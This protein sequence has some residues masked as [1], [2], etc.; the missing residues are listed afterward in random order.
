VIGTTNDI[1][2]LATLAPSD[3]ATGAAVA[4]APELM[5]RIMDTPVRTRRA[6]KGAAIGGV[7]VGVV[8]AAA[9][10]VTLVITA[11][12]TRSEKLGADP[13]PSGAQRQ[14]VEFELGVN[15]APGVDAEGQELLN[16]GASVLRSRADALGI[17]GFEVTPASGRLFAFVPGATETEPAG[18]L[19]GEAVLGVYD[20][21]KIVRSAGNPFL[22]LQ[23]GRGLTAA[24]GATGSWYVVHRR[25][26]QSGTKI[27]V[28]GP[29]FSRAAGEQLA[30]PRG[31]VVD[32]P[33]GVLLITERGI[34]DRTRRSGVRNDYHLVKGL[35]LATGAQ[36]VGAT[37]PGGERRITATPEFAAR[38]ASWAQKV[39]AAARK[40]VRLLLTVNGEVAVTRPASA[41]PFRAGQFIQ[42]G[43]GTQSGSPVYRPDL[44]LRVAPLLAD[45]GGAIALE[46][47]AARVVGRPGRRPSSG[48]PVPPGVAKLLA[49]DRRITRDASEEGRAKL[50]RPES[51]RLLAGR[52]NEPLPF[53][54]WGGLR[55]DGKERLLLVSQARPRRIPVDLTCALSPERPFADFCASMMVMGSRGPVRILGRVAPDVAT[56][57]VTVKGRKPQTVTAVDGWFTLLTPT[58]AELATVVT[59]DAMG[60]LVGRTEGWIGSYALFP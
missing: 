25:Q 19:L 24:G 35:P 26:S 48:V 16:L 6:R 50:V 39:P 10:S 53:A 8:A 40:E 1:E 12:T 51:L 22:L 7:A 31:E 44:P 60:A 59:Y 30:G 56:V 58:S 42:L 9:I 38:L 17:E 18:T 3:P 27:S 54:V 28:S 47:L 21:R 43:P 23:V 5:A 14:G 49:S 13:A 33:P 45:Q 2:T 11:G 55:S 36:V 57:V 46:R 37:S 15:A 52:S 20:S 34:P 41:T 29:V 32:L 4:D